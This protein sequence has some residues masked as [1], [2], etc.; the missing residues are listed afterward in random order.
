MDRRSAAE[1]AVTWAGD[2]G[3]EVMRIGGLSR[4][5]GMPVRAL[6]RYADMG[7]IYSAGRS[8]AGYRLFGE[9]ALWCVQVITGLR[10]LGLT[11]AEISQL[12]EI[13]LQAPGEPIGPHLAGRLRDVRARLD[14]RI[15]GLQELR[16]RIEDFETSHAAE[17]AGDGFRAQD[18]LSGAAGG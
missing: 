8:P 15:A 1:S 6:R 2:A 10:A 5:S 12:A 18:P 17:L 11:V 9:P 4:R 7:L 16:R 3:A 14:E 13:Y